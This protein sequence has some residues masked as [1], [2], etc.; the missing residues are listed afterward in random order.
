MMS[1]ESS[2]IT[3]VI[4]QFLGTS[5]PFV[6]VKWNYVKPTE[7]NTLFASVGLMCYI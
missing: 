4:T 5:A 6:S 2:L 1:F 3:L 7:A